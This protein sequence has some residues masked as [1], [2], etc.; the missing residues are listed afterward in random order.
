MH[1]LQ[2]QN[3]PTNRFEELDTKISDFEL[4]WEVVPGK[5]KANSLTISPIGGLEKITENIQHLTDSTIEKLVS[6]KRIRNA[7][8]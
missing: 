8:K 7:T 6:H 3:Y 4:R 2:S 5:E 1:D